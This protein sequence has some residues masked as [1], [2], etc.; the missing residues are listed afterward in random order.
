[1]FGHHGR[2]LRIDVSD[3][4]FRINTYDESFAR[5]YLGGNGFAVKILYDSLKPG[6]D[7]F[8]PSNAVV[9]AVGPKIGRASCRERV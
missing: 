4:S 1:M 5:A 2:I 7:P 8:D 6:I 9:F 3:S